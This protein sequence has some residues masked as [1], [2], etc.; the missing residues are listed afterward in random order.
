MDE[1]ARILVVNDDEDAGE[2]VARILTHAGYAVARVTSNDAAIAQAADEPPTCVVL[3]LA[4]GVGGSLKL[5][6]TLR[7]HANPEV[8]AAGAVMVARQASN[9]LFSWQSGVDAFLVRP[10]H[11]DE[12]VR[13]VAAVLA[14]S[15]EERTRHRQE[16]EAQAT[17]G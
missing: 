16:Q 5:L 10:F 2:L 1:P 6:E 12:L 17:G 11:A 15:P 8:A 4:S 9:R 3:D 13:E 14:R 7:T